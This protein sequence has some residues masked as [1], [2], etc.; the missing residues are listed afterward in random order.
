MNVFRRMIS[1]PTVRGSRFQQYYGRV[2]RSGEGYP[3]ADEARRDMA[4][5]ERSTTLFGWPK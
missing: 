1:R 2:L 4:A 3:T 5:Y